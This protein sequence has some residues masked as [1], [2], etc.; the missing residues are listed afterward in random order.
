M[1]AHLSILSSITQINFFIL[2]FRRAAKIL[3]YHHLFAFVRSFFIDFL[4]SPKSHYLKLNLDKQRGGISSTLWFSNHPMIQTSRVLLDEARGS[5][6]PQSCREKRSFSKNMLLC[7]S[8]QTRHLRA[9]SS[10]IYNM[11][12]L[13]STRSRN[14][15]NCLQF[16]CACREFPALLQSHVE[17]KMN[18]RE[19]LYVLISGNWRLFENLRVKTFRLCA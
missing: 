3:M 8:C 12:L 15:L 17:R 4:I 7:L 6:C 2:L 18:I 11:L 14:P 5:R 13:L 9:Y 19:L 16:R 1:R 10:Y